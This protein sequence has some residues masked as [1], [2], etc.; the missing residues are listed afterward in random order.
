MQSNPFFLGFKHACRQACAVCIALAAGM[1]PHTSNMS[2][3]ACAC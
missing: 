1:F 3:L 2:S